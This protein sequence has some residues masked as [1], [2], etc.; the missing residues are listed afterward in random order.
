MSATASLRLASLSAPGLRSKRASAVVV[1][2][3]TPCLAA[4]AITASAPDSRSLVDVIDVLATPSSATAPTP[5][6]ADS[7]G[8]HN[9][10]SDTLGCRANCPTIIY[11]GPGRLPAERLCQPAAPGRR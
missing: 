6:T 5:S 9:P 11:S 1:T 7:F 2:T 3:L 8:K 4:A 10:L